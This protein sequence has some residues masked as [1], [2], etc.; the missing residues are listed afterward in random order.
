MSETYEN[1]EAAYAVC[2]NYKEKIVQV[3]MFEIRDRMTFFSVVAVAMKPTTDGVA[4]GQYGA[5]NYL[6]RRAGYDTREEAR[7]LIAVG[8]TDADGTTQFCYDPFSWTSGGRTIRE[9]HRYIEEHWCQLQS[10]AV[11][12][13]EYLLGEVAEPKISERLT[14]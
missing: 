10:G 11:V 4:S 3:K 14:T 6:L 8:R 2:S 9:A 13:V 12:D 1:L 7:T 5:E